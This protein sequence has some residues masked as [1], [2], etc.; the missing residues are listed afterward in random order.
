MGGENSKD[1]QKYI[2]KLYRASAALKIFLKH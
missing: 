2:S 1:Y